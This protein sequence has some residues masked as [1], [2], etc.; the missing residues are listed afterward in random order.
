M[1]SQCQNGIFQPNDKNDKSEAT[2]Q[3]KTL[4]QK[5]ILQKVDLLQDKVEI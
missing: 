1:T 5:E 3:E 2:E 4:L